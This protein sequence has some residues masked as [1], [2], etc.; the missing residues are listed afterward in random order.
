M[1]LDISRQQDFFMGVIQH[2]RSL[3]SFSMAYNRI[4]DNGFTMVCDVVQKMPF[5]KALDVANCFITSKSKETLIYLISLSCPRLEVL[6]L[7]GNLLIRAD[8]M[9]LKICGESKGTELF[10]H[11]DVYWGIETPL[12]YEV[13]KDCFKYK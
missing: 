2:L 10:V 4:Q 13:S 8:E 12:R 3:Q 6:M 1:T 7:Q 5:L 9:D 11:D